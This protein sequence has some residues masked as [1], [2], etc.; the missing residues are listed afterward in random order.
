MKPVEGGYELSD[1]VRNEA[2]QWLTLNLNKSRRLMASLNL[3]AFTFKSSDP[4][5]YG[6]SLV[7]SRG[8]L[9]P[10]S[11]A[12]PSSFLCRTNQPSNRPGRCLLI[13]QERRNRAPLER[14][15][16]QTNP[17][18]RMAVKVPKM[19]RF[20]TNP[21]DANLKWHSWLQGLK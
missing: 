19:H 18:H 1:I 14:S 21:T 13:S 2:I 11:C 17:L 15:I 3:A 16:H 7:T 10:M 12:L 5:P 6:L 8:L 20:Q 4:L 9:K